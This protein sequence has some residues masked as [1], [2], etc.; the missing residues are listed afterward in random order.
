[1]RLLMKRRRIRATLRV[2]PGVAFGKMETLMQA[3]GIHVFSHRTFEHEDDRTFELH[4]VGAT[5]Q[6]D[7]MVDSLR[8]DKDVISIVTE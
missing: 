1:R 8:R 3:Q 2:R 7:L 6:L 5:Q 4:L